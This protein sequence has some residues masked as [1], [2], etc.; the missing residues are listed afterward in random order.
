MQ[1]SPSLSVLSSRVGRTRVP[2][3]SQSRLKRGWSP[4]GT[5]VPWGLG[6]FCPGGR[7]WRPA[8]SGA[9]TRGERPL[10]GPGVRVT[11][12]AVGHPFSS[13]WLQGEGGCWDRGPP[14]RSGA[15]PG[16]PASAGRLAAPRV[17][18]PLGQGLGRSGGGRRGHWDS[19]A[20]RTGGWVSLLGP[21]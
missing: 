13:P 16:T 3:G 9:A 11:R 4:S 2:S 20:F 19:E 6:T 18:T 10:P 5:R 12:R 7:M 14:R 17:R 15:A 21:V 1:L 8:G